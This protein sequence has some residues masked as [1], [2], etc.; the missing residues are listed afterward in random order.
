MYLI[1]TNLSDYSLKLTL[2]NVAL[3]NM[4]LKI[5]LQIKLLYLVQLP[6]TTNEYSSITSDFYCSSES[7]YIISSLLN[8]LAKFSF[9]LIKKDLE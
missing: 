6:V 5:T 3:C 1:K 8:N 7:N 2:L 9:F 4:G